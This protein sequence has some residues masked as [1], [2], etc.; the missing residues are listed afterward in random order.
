VD[1]QQDLE[2][3]LDVVVGHLASR[4]DALN[5]VAH[6]G[7]RFEDWLKWEALIAIHNSLLVTPKPWYSCAG[8]EHSEFAAD[9]FVGF[10]Q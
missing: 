2:A 4:R 9:L 8:V 6:H 10:N 3:L 1:T 7:N 5:A